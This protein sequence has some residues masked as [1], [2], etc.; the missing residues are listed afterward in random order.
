MG[1]EWGGSVLLSWNGA[2]RKRRGLMASWPQIGVPIG[3]LLRTGMV[4]LMSRLAGPELHGW[5]WRIPFLAS[6]VLV[7]IG[8]YVRL[9]VME[10][11]SS[12]SCKKRSGRQ[13]PAARGHQQHPRRSSLGASCGCRS[14]RRSTS[15]SPSCSPTAP[16]TSSCTRAAAE[17]HPGRRG[18][19]ARQRAALRPPLRP[20]RPQRST[21]SASSASALFAFPYFGLLDTQLWALS[22]SASSL[23]LIFHDMQ[24]G[25]QAASSPR[26]SRPASATAARAW[27]T[28]SPR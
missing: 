11:P 13:A 28:S 7:A 8:L 5:A 17:L 25:P 3:L 20:V 9:R 6:L 21:A 4:K 16:S 15:S 10:S 22:C 23:S 26:A 14:R 18:R 27:A 12:P 1:G 24:Y 2:A 19:R